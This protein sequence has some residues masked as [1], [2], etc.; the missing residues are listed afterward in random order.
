MVH[1]VLDVRPFLRV[2][3]IL[4][5]IGGNRRIGKEPGQLI[6]FLCDGV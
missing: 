6:I 5:M 4:L 3:L 1:H 2:L